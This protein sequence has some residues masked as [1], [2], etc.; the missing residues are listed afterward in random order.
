M[1]TLELEIRVLG[2][3][4]LVSKFASDIKVADFLKQIAALK[5]TG[6][7]EASNHVLPLVLTQETTFTQILLTQLPSR[8]SLM[9]DSFLL[10][11]L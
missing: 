3:K 7:L 11:L 2:G 5:P 8:S 6:T 10:S 1:E 9:A 4:T